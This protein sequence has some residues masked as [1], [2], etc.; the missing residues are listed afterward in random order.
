MICSKQLPSPMK[1]CPQCAFANEERFPACLWC[2]AL[3]VNVQ[4]TPAADPDHPEHAQRKLDRERHVRSHRQWMFAAAVY[5]LAAMGLAVLPGMMHDPMHGC[6]CISARRPSSP[7][8]AAGI[9]WRGPTQRHAG[10]M[11][12]WST[13]LVYF[14]GP[15]HVFIFFMLV[16]HLLMPNLFWHWTDLIEGSQSL[17]KRILR[18][19]TSGVD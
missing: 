2:N 16:G 18:R 10:C 1:V 19:A 9:G 4:S 17:T 14:F 7:Q 6:P 5:C 3:L 13:A 15:V 12:R 8:P 11:G